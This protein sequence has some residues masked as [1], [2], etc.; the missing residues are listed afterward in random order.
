MKI[1]ASFDHLNGI[2]V[3]LGCSSEH[4]PVV[5]APTVELP[6]TVDD[7]NVRTKLREEYNIE[8]AGGFGPLAGKIWRIGL[9]GFS[10]RRENVLRLLSAMKEIISTG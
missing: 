6:P 10:S 4:N 9:M 7:L 8:I 3:V 2:F 5:S 1:N